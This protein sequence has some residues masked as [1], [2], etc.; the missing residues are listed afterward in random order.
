MSDVRFLPDAPLSD[1]TELAFI[2]GRTF[3]NATKHEEVVNRHVAEIEL[4]RSAV[5]GLQLAAE[6]DRLRI[7][8]MRNDLE[9]WKG[10]DMEARTPTYKI[11]RAR[12]LAQA[13]AE[14]HAD[15]NVGQVAVGIAQLLATESESGEP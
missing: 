1:A 13:L 7:E 8:K 4:L 12:G 14:T 2:D 10:A 9:E 6:S 3:V 5:E 15:T 11:A